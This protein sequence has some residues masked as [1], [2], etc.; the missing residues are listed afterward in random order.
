MAFSRVDVRLSFFLIGSQAFVSVAVRSLE[1]HHYF[2]KSRFAG[3]FAGI[4]LPCKTANNSF[5]VFGR[6]L[7]KCGPGLAILIGALNCKNGSESVVLEE[8]CAD[9]C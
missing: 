2:G 7:L 9:T 4:K 1:F 6:L 5:G 8:K 3:S